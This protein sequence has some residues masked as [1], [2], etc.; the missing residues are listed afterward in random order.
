MGNILPQQPA[1]AVHGAAEIVAAIENLGVKLESTVKKDAS[2]ALGW[3]KSNWLHLVN[4][5]GI[6]AIG[7][8]VFGLLA[9][10]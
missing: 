10:L 2:S 6:A 7:V 8:K 4:M 1:S 5:G 3:V 9:K